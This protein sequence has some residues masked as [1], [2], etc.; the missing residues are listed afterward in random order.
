MT[1]ETS[2][3]VNGLVLLGLYFRRNDCLPVDFPL[4]QS[5]MNVSKPMVWIRGFRRLKQS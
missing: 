2:I 5:I 4:N 3:Y 1:Q